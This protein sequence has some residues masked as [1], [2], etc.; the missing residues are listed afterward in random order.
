MRE[1][2]ILEDMDLKEVKEESNIEKNID[3]NK[4][5]R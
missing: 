3:I 4:F 1:Q 5:I 2:T